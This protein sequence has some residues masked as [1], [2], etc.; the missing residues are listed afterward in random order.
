MRRLSSAYKRRHLSFNE[1]HWRE[2]ARE[3]EREREMA[4]SKLCA[5][6]VIVVVLLMPLLAEGMLSC[7]DNCRWAPWTGSYTCDDMSDAW[8]GCPQGCHRCI[9][10]R[11]TQSS[12]ICSDNFS[13]CPPPCE[14]EPP[15]GKEPSSA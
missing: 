6:A 9:C 2:G 7:C 5:S 1:H 11:G 3:R 8:S 10:D 14:E 15:T 13:V 12:C 4:G